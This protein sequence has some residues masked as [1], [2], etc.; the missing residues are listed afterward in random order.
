MVHTMVDP[1]IY[2]F[3]PRFDCGF[4]SQLFMENFDAKVMAHFDNNAI[5]DHR[6]AI[7]ASLIEARDNGDV[8]VESVMEEELIKKK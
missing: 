7:A 2:L 8:A 3:F 6:K 4:F 1:Y 5:P